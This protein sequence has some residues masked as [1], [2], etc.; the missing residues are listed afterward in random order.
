MGISGAPGKIAIPPSS[1]SPSEIQKLRFLD[2]A[3]RPEDLSRR[4]GNWRI[5][6]ILAGVIVLIALAS[7]ASLFLRLADVHVTLSDVHIETGVCRTEYGGAQATTVFYNFTLSNSGSRGAYV[8]LDFYADGKLVHTDYAW[9]VPAG[10]SETTD[11]DLVVNYCN[12]ASGA[13]EIRDITPAS[14]G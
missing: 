10:S 8:T 11:I 12:P 3:K 14:G 2:T 6:A 5:S 9:S 13:V 1:A 4:A 7:Y